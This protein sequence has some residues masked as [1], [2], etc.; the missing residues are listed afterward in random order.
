[1]T[2]GLIPQKDGSF[3]ISIELP[4]TVVAAQVL[5]VLA[6]LAAQGAVVHP[7]TAQ[8]IMVLG[9]SEEAA[10]AALEKLEAAGAM[11]RKSG[12]S[13]QPRTCVGLPY[14][15]IALKE[16][17]SLSRAIYEAFPNEELP[18]KLKVA[19]SG[20]PACCSWANMID[21]GFVGARE[22]FKV[23]VGGKGGYQPKAGAYLTL[24]S[25]EDE[26]VSLMRGVLAFFKERG[27]KKKRLGA[28]LEGEGLA[29]LKKFLGLEG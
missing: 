24:V 29:D 16:T 11:I 10:K 14:C 5:S 25:G 12:K 17:F 21:L 13:L 4:G 1:M 26:A 28:L 23:Y 18:H 6:E 19:I 9:L 27:Q 8:K 22:G 20:C 2:P 15:K 3:A 7:T